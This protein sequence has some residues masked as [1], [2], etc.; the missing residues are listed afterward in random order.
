MHCCDIGPRKKKSSREEKT[1]KMSHLVMKDDKR[2]RTVDV[3]ERW[4]VNKDAKE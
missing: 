4:K 2:R 3:C 1:K